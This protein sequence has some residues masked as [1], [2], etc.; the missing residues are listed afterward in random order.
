[1]KKEFLGKQ[2]YKKSYLSWSSTSSLKED[3]LNRPTWQF[4]RI[5]CRLRA[6]TLQLCNL[7]RNMGRFQGCK[8]R[9]ELRPKPSALTTVSRTIISKWTGKR[10][11]GLSW[12]P[13]TSRLCPST[14]G[15]F[16]RHPDISVPPPPS[17]PAMPLSSP[18]S[19]R[20]SSPPSHPAMFLCS[21]SW[22]CCQPCCVAAAAP[23]LLWL[24]RAGVARP[25]LE[26]QRPTARS[27]SAEGSPTTWP[28]ICLLWGDSPSESCDWLLP[29]LLDPSGA[30]QPIRKGADLRCEVSLS[31]G[32]EGTM[33]VSGSPRGLSGR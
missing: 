29:C 25:W 16:Q 26:R 23:G 32:S 30:G 27:A 1:M 6:E 17:P 24:R 4:F 7:S 21:L 8:E 28:P 31:G 19:S 3:C 2:F 12:L 13:T 14:D 18:L 5:S 33:L 20:L 10:R 22:A 11:P 9:T 15:G